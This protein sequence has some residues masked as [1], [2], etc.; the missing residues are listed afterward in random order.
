MNIL[1]GYPPATV[2]CRSKSTSKSETSFKYGTL[3]RIRKQIKECLKTKRKAQP[4][5]KMPPTF[6]LNPSIYVFDQKLN[7]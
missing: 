1:V 7:K 6:T 5:K 2:P 3:S 4:I